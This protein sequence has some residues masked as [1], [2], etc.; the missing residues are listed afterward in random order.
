VLQ[1]RCRAVKES[2][3]HLNLSELSNQKF[4]F[5]DKNIMDLKGPDDDVLRLEVLGF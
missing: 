3:F 1:L 5:K 4:D 2:E